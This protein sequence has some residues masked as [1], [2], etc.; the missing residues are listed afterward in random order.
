MIM[1][2]LAG[3]VGVFLGGTVAFWRADVAHRDQSQSL[4]EWIRASAARD[5]VTSAGQSRWAE[6]ASAFFASRGQGG[7]ARVIATTAARE[8]RAAVW[9]SR[10]AALDCR[11]PRDAIR[12]LINDSTEGTT[13]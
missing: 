4:C 7:A 8:R 6:T 2:M 11:D 13:P 3:L 5:A 12:G 9:R 10:A 1:A